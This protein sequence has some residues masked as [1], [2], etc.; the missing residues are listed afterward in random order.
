MS[1]LP[2]KCNQEIP[3]QIHQFFKGFNQIS[4][5]FYP[6]FSN[7]PIRKIVPYFKNFTSIFYLKFLENG[8]DL[9]WSNQ[10]KPFEKKSNKQKILLFIFG[11]S[12]FFLSRPAPTPTALSHR[13][14]GHAPTPTPQSIISPPAAT[15]TRR[16]WPPLHRLQQDVH[17]SPRAPCTVLVQTP[18]PPSLPHARADPPLSPLFFFALVKESCRR[19][20]DPLS[21]TL[22]LVRVR[23]S[24]PKN[25]DASSSSA[26]LILPT[27]T[28]GAPLKPLGW[29]E[30]TSTSPLHGEHL[31]NQVG[32][33]ETTSTCR[34]LNSNPGHF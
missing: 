30:T 33:V 21:L 3:V 23:S 12:V 22:P 14:P 2:S 31:R 25:L 32:W 10:F 9:F 5:K 11:W 28:T 16:A 1:S 24:T 20:V 4:F 29:V 18:P 19:R 13:Q 8:K 7:V 17:H 27:T 15:A 6:K 26:A 34:G